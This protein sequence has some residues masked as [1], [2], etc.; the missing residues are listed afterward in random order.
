MS[1]RKEERNKQ[2][3]AGGENGQN[4]ILSGY[5]SPNLT[6]YSPAD[7]LDADETRPLELLL[8][9]TGTGTNIPYS[10]VVQNAMSRHL[11]EM[12][13]NNPQPMK[14]QNSWKKKLREFL[15]TKNEDLLSFY[16][17]RL[18]ENS[19]ISRVENF[20]KKYG[21]MNDTNSSNAQKDRFLDV[22]GQERVLFLDE[23]EEKLQKEG[24]SKYV[25]MIFQVK[26]IMDSYRETGERV[27]FLENT[28][29]SKLDI[30]DKAVQKLTSI[31]SLGQNDAL[32]P[33]IE[34]VQNYL[35]HIFDENKIEETYK[36]LVLTYKRF[37]FLRESLQ[38]LW[39]FEGAQ[40]EPL[41]AIC[42]NDSVQFALVPCGHTFCETC[43]K[44]QV[45]NC[46]I[47]R[48]S[49]RERIKLFFG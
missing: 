41:C 24:K 11:H 30:L 25:E 32:P 26:M 21:R 45:M 19:P 35:N 18:P 12:K 46:Y 15:T 34:S 28:L 47:C 43:C 44:R 3:S 36:E 9:P 38:F 16:T 17:K 42:F 14:I 29:K 10:T 2:M 40:R 6:G 37:F 8:D 39:T 48:V 22:S 49:V 5:V 7:F 33:L 31:C 23:L 13:E 27:I 20:M 1:I 4:F